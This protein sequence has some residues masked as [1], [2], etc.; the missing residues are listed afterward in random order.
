MEEGFFLKKLKTIVTC[1]LLSVIILVNN[2]AFADDFIENQPF[3]EVFT[4][5]EYIDKLP[6]INA[7]SAIVMDM[8]TGRVLFEKNAYSK[9]SMASTTKIMTAIIAVEEGDLKGEVTVSKRAA[10]IRGSSAGLQEGQKIV[11]EELLYGLMMASGNDAAI[12]IA[13]HIGSTVEEFANMMTKKAYLIG[14]R[15]TAFKTPHGLDADGHYST[16]FDMAMITRYALENP[17]ISKIVGTKCIQTSMGTL[18]NTNEMLGFYEGADGVKTGYTGKAG[19][20]LVTSVTRE[21][22]RIISVVLGCPTRAARAQASRDILNYAY[23]NYSNHTLMTEGVSVKKIPIDRGISDYVDIKTI[24]NIILPLKNN[25]IENLKKRVHL[26]EILEA[27]VI[28]GADAGYVQFILDDQVIA[29]SSLKICQDVRRKVF[30]DYLG[31]IIREWS[32]FLR[33]GEL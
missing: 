32:R 26:P 30:I 25:E 6:V 11:L 17:L 19:R 28:A 1:I 18:H 16:A 21:D 29:Q 7:I 33:N 14:A 20:C 31:D 4:K 22:W 8:D 9:M 10:S 24:E 15:N 23:E 13:E 12:A 27:P 5:T 3:T 2:I